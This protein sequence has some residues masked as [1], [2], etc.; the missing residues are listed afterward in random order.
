MRAQFK[1]VWLPALVGLAE[2][3][4]GQDP[5][6]ASALLDEAERLHQESRIAYWD[7]NRVEELRS[8]VGG[9]RSIAG[10]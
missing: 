7:P 2:A 4:A 5:P 8:R 9:R 1:L 3:V 10:G 6:R